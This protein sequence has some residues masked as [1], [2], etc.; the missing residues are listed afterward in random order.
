MICQILSGAAIPHREAQYPD[1]PDGTY[2]V[3]L[4]GAEADGSDSDNCIVTHDCTIE[5]Y[6]PTIPIGN[7][8]R[9]RLLAELDTHGIHYTRQGWY[10]MKDLRRYQEVVEFSYIEKI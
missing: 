3:W 4:D 9:K 6:A 1:P 8:D 10:W 7:E 2:A 5:L